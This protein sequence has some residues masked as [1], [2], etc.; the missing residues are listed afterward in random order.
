LFNLRCSAS[1]V[2]LALVIGCGEKVP[3][4]EQGIV[5]GRATLDGA[6]LP[7]GVIK[8]VP[9][10]SSG[11]MAAGTIDSQGYFNV[12]SSPSQT[13]VLPGTYQVIVEYWKKQPELNV[14]KGELGVPLKYTQLGKSGFQVTV[15]V[16][17]TETLNLDM[18]SG[19]K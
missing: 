17:A 11:Q 9:D 13:G 8:L 7:A 1:I 12:Q 18:K 15:K 6:P 14:S 19:A 2:I 16:G 5:K 10:A 3:V 4:K